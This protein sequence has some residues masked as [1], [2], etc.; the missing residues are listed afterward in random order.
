MRPVELRT[1][2]FEITLETKMKCVL[3]GAVPLTAAVVLAVASLSASVASAAADTY[4]PACYKPAPGV[5][6][7]I[8]YPARSGP[9]RVALVNGYTGI[10]WR[11]QMIQESRAWAARP[12]NA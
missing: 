12:E 5:A 6:T 10:P 11:P 2:R 1:V 4:M 3:K 8:R 7:T 9:Y